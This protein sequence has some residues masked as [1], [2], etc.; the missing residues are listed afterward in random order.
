MR[1]LLR[2]QPRWLASSTS[3]LLLAGALTVVTN[4]APAA[5]AEADPV[6]TKW[7]SVDAGSYHAC[8]LTEGGVAYCWGDGSY[9]ALGNG[10][11]SDQPA[12]VKVTMPSGRIFTRISAGTYTTCAIADNGAAYCWGLDGD[13]QLGNGNPLTDSSVPVAVTM[14]PGRTFT[15]I[16]TGSA[17]VCAVADNGRVYC[18]GDD[19]SGSLGNG[20]SLPGTDSSVPDE[21]TTL[22]GASD[23]TQN[24]AH[25]CAL[26]SGSISCWG[27]DGDGGLGN[28]GS[29]SGTNTSSPVSVLTLTTATMVESGTYHLCALVSAGDAYCWGDNYWGAVGTGQSVPVASGSTVHSPSKV[30]G[31]HVFTD[32]ATGSGVDTC[33]VD[34]LGGAYCWGFNG[35]EALG[36]GTTDGNDLNGSTATPQ[37]VYGL[38]SGV[39]KVTAGSYFACALLLTGDIKCWGMDQ[40][41]ALGNGAP[42]NGYSAAPSSLSVTLPYSYVLSVDLQGTGGGS[43][44]S[45]PAGVSCSADCSKSFDDGTAVT[46]SASATSGSTFDGWSGESCSGTGTCTVTLDQARSVWRRSLL[47]PRPLL[48]RRRPLRHRRPLQH[49]RPLR[50]RHRRRPTRRPPRRRRH[51]LNSSTSAS[52][53][54]ARAA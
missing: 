53:S 40:R 6:A 7:A 13:G 23:V 47:T 10:S 17:T 34:D 48:R 4:V 24:G 41:G 11:S 35:S 18:W 5:P 21:I 31:G 43:V 39:S 36:D 52:R 2:R 46:L 51:R 15:D 20:G 33:A 12:P 28:G 9:G 25:G 54:T 19:Y 27:Y 8:A 38:S 1:R 42:I 30:V 44:T 50:Q 16:S 26:V 32:I 14:P 29:D 45:S 22:S 49:R 3:V 37:A